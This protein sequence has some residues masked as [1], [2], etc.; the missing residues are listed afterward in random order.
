MLMITVL[1]G[2]AFLW[3][4]ALTVI[5]LYRFKQDKN[6]NQALKEEKLRE[7]LLGN[8]KKIRELEN[9]VREIQHTL[10]LLE[11]LSK[12]SLRRAGLVRFD[13][14]EDIGGELSFSLALIDDWGN[15]FVITSIQS[16]HEGR[17]Y[18]KPLE[19]GESPFRLSEEEKEAVRRARKKD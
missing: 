18:A 19:G 12:S 9:R 6:L 7:I 4:T 13:A 5:F 15:G 2:F 8:E 14:F 17:V 11:S 3:L 1:I 10:K 16:R